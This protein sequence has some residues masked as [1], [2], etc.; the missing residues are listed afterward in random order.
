[1]INWRDKQQARAFML[2]RI[3]I[4]LDEGLPNGYTKELFDLKC[5]AVFQY[6]YE[7]YA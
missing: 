1:V 7:S 2:E 6:V 4:T 3:K 5:D